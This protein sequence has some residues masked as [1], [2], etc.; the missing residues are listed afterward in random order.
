VLVVL[1]RPDA[2]QL[3]DQLEHKQRK[4][5]QKAVGISQPLPLATVQEATR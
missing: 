1:R 5:T 2:Q 4:Q 3:A